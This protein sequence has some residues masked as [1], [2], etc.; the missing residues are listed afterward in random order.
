ELRYT[1]MVNRGL[2]RFQ[3]GRLDE[4]VADLEAAIRINGRHY[5]AFASLAQV[6]R[7]QKKWDQAVECFTQA[8]RAQPPVASLYRGRAAAARERDDQRAEHRTAA[9][10]DLE[11]AIRCASPDGPGLASDHLQRAELL[12]RDERYDLALGACDAAV[13]VAPDLDSAHA[14]R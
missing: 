13:K 14:L 5:N 9:L 2:M 4:A 8:I 7:Q 10:R 1:V 11:D 12:R 3:R 6:R